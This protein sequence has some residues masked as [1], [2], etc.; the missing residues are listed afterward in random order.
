MTA[1]NLFD[2]TGRVAIVT[3]GN[4]GLGKGMAR[5]LAEAGA[6]VVIAARDQGKSKAAVDELMLQAERAG[7]TVIK[8][9]QA[10]FWGGYS[11]YFADPDGHL[12]ELA[13][14]PFFWIGP[15]G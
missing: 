3:G 5:A 15:E 9:P 4:G 7:A 12:W 2:L 8:P 6:D 11:G 1:K 13:Y 14:N 10:V